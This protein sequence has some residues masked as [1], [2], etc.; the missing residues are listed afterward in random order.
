MVAQESL[1]IAA[2]DG[3]RVYRVLGSRTGV[4]TLF[5][6]ADTS[7]GNRVALRVYAPELSADPGFSEAFERT[8]EIHRA[9]ELPHVVR[10]VGSSLDRNGDGPQ[11][12]ALEFVDG[13]TLRERVDFAP[14]T[15]TPTLRLAQRLAEALD[16]A[17]DA[18]LV[19][20]RLASRAILLDDDDIEEPMLTDFGV[21]KDITDEDEG[22]ARSSPGRLLG[23]VDCI[24]P[25]EIRGAP[26]DVRSHVYALSAIVFECLTGSP[27]FAS[28]WRPATL[29]AH[30]AEPPPKVTEGAPRVPAGVGEVLG[31]GMAKAP[32]ER[33]PT[34]R[35]LTAELELAAGL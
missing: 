4:S 20:R 22:V 10:L 25:E 16:A 21:G 18:G 26:P 32:D 8:V 5:D 24:A 23:D 19:H 9:T 6:A 12:V 13:A 35:H 29:H 27:P 34:A 30:L 31:R 14:L 17:S 33:P 28:D 11:F 3:Y 1:E 7:T 2:P 15:L